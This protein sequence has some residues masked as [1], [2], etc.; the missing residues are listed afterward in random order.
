MITEIWMNGEPLDLY[1]GTDIKHT[2]QINDVAD[3]KDR[4]TSFTESFTIPRTARN[5]YLL[6]G[7]GIPSNTSVIPYQKPNAVVKI[8]GF[9]FLVNAWLNVKETDEEYKIYIYSGIIEFFKKF[10]NATIGGS[11]K[12]LITEIDHNKNLATV[13]ASQTNDNLKYAYLFA[14]FNGR[15]HRKTDSSV[16]N[17]D[18]VVPS[19]LVSYLFEKIHQFAGYTF[20]G[21]FIGSDDY[22]NWYITY[23][24]APEDTQSIVYY[25][26]NDSF[27]FN[28][29]GQNGQQN[30]ELLLSFNNGSSNGVKFIETGI[31]SI[32][33][34]GNAGVNNPVPSGVNNTSSVEF[35]YSING[36]SLISL[37]NPGN[38]TI[39]INQNDV[40]V[41]HYTVY[42]EWNGNGIFGAEIKKLEDVS[43]TEELTD[44]KIT[45]F[46]KDIYNILGL[47]PMID[48]VKKLI[49]YKSNY[50]RFKSTEVEDWSNYLV[51]IEKE[52]YSFGTYA[53]QNYLRYKYND[54]EESH[55]DGYFKIENENLDDS[56]TLFS[57]YTYSVEKEQSEFLINSTN[58]ETVRVFK[59]YEKEAQDGSTELK[60]KGL[61]KRYF[62]LRMRK[63]SINAVIGS[64]IQNANQS[65]SVIKI[66]EFSKLSMDYFIGK[67]YSAFMSVVGHP[68]LWDAKLIIPYPK[69]LKLDLS[70]VYYFKQLQ[71][72]CIINKIT[73]D[74]NDATAELVMIKDFRIL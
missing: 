5:V 7:L 29:N 25:S 51:S 18:Y 30:D 64:D 47:T 65:V 32:S 36:G 37:N 2:L 43:F 11:M 34:N 73:F 53:K 59:L 33:V 21:S 4:Q 49:E 67:Y 72:Y 24:K 71:Q 55:S 10:E 20:T 50:E 41:F 63:L 8:D 45:D 31:Y 56:K 27:S 19:V 40:I 54:Q 16:L 17:I 35:Y 61:S 39:S 1:I 22:E 70:K 13:A 42:A 44:L 48:N 57:S 6:K 68:V 3:V 74:Q 15:T 26:G 23:P 62:Y 28:F 66:G 46:L 58:T 52:S 12:E 38:I 14:D 69:L 9:D 60:Y